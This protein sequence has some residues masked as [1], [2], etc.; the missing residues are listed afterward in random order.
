V[1][2]R[3]IISL[4]LVLVSSPLFGGPWPREQGKTFVSLSSLITSPYAVDGEDL[5]GYHALY[6]E[7]GL[8]RQL[9]F[10]IDAGMDETWNYGAIGFL[11][12]PVF[13]NDGPHRFALQLG[14]GANSDGAEF[15]PLLQAGASWGRGLETPLG[16]GWM[17]F[18]AQA[19]YLFD[20]GDF[21]TK[22]D[23]TL[24]VKP[25]ERWKVMLQLQ[26]ANYPGSEPML[27]AAPSVAYSVGPNRHLEVGA[28]FGLFNEDRFG[29]K[30]GSWVDF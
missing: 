29:L 10:G 6:I 25:T 30:I 15:E 24:G 18:D 20:S 4:A 7:H 1:L 22:A 13:E 26:A 12:M 14:V 8:A 9:T 21:V 23:V 11:R 16:G 19:Q 5:R 2:G 28:Q 3:Y 17:T 27:R